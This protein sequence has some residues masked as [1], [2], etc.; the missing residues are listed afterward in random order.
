[1]FK[2]SSDMNNSN[3][4]DGNDSDVQC[5]D[6]DTEYVNDNVTK[7]LQRLHVYDRVNIPD[8]DGINFTRKFY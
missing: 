6:G 4:D 1:M 2:P 8:E 7:K 3:A 5:V